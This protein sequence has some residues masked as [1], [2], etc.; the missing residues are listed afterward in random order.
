VILAILQARMS[1]TRLPGKVLKPI[2]NR[3]MLSLQLERVRRS[4]Q[5][6]TLLVAT[7]VDAS[8]DSIAELCQREKVGCFRGSLNDVLDRYY[9]A[10][11]PYEPAHVVRLTGDCPLS[12]PDIID[13]V[14]R[15]HVAESFQYTSNCHPP[16]FP[17][18]LDV[19]IVQYPVLRTAWQEAKETYQREHVMPFLWQQPERF[20]LGNLTNSEDYSHMRW[21]VDH[22]EDFALVTEIFENLYPANPEF[23]FREILAFV[24]SQPNLGNIN[25]QFK[26][27]ESLA[28]QLADLQERK[29]K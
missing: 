9:Q 14:I 21:T 2:L 10:A 4:T 13:R 25:A 19:E 16:T 22:P 27:N 7:S 28:K 24:Q 20:R 29:R 15:Y 6:D 8:D 11:L 23:G 26:R 18:G 3:P 5:I 17:N 1:S 12:D